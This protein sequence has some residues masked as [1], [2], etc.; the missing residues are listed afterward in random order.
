MPRQY[1]PRPISEPLPPLAKLVL[2]D[3]T[4]FDVRIDEAEQ[5]PTRDTVRTRATGHVHFPDGNLDDDEVKVT[6][7]VAAHSK[8]GHAILEVFGSWRDV[9]GTWL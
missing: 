5:R 8:L 3:G 7:D 2:P 6:I 4:E 1:V 9:Q